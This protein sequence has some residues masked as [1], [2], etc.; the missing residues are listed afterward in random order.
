MAD[1]YVQVSGRQRV[2]PCASLSVQTLVSLC[3]LASTI[4]LLT[5]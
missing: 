4:L 1:V 5:S 2:K 3:S